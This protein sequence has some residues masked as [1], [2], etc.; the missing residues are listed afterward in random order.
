MNHPLENIP[1]VK[2][3]GLSFQVVEVSPVLASDWLKRNGK[4]RKVKEPTVEAYSRDMRNNAW[5]L[6]HQGVAFD[7][8][9][10]LID[11]Q[12]RLEAI[13]RSRR[14]V[15]LFVSAGWTVGGTKNKTMDAVDRGVSRSL[16]DQLSLQHGV[17]D[18][19]RVVQ[20]VNAI[21]AANFGLQRVF[22][23]TTASVLAVFE[24]YAPE[25]KW[26]LSHPVKTNGIKSA[27]VGALMVL[28]RAVWPE[29][30]EDFY[31]RLRDGVNLTR[32]NPALHLRNWLMGSSMDHSPYT[33]RNTIAYALQEFVAGR[34]M[35]KIVT[36]STAGMKALL[37]KQAEKS[38]TVCKI[39]GATPVLPADKTE[40]KGPAKPQPSSARSPI[41][42]YSP[43][44]V[45]IGDSL[46]GSFTLLD[47]VARL[48]EPNQPG[49]WLMLWMK[50]GWI[51]SAG[52]NAYRKTEKWGK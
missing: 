33:I 6:T 31:S 35:E 49:T 8:G 11:G 34:P 32:D 41:S 13:V 28:A 29:K 5:L 46:V 44:A 45:K 39:Y 30:T 38:A 16:A 2:I 36:H 4:N 21:A 15:K 10:K 48:D 43:E 14:T 9:G 22:K 52:A 37:S 24:L 23:G 42:P 18:A 26:L 7:D 17:A 1:A 50:K 27:Q 12:H 40:S 25:L 51:T 47:L 19:A 20:V 3:P